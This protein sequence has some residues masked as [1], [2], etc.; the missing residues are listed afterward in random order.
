[1]GPPLPDDHNKRSAI[2]TTAGIDFG[3][4]GGG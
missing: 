2:D 3:G 4:I 1:M